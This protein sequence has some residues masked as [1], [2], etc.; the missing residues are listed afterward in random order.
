M[1]Q[2]V[3]GFTEIL[4]QILAEEYHETFGCP[5]GRPGVSPCWRMGGQAECISLDGKPSGG[6]SDDRAARSDRR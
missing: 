2:T 5:C 3:G 6:S 4:T 1:A